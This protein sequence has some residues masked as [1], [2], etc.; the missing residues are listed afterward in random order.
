MRILL[1]LLILQWLL[2][3]FVMLLF[4]M[5]VVVRIIRHYW[6]FPIPGPLTRVID[7][8]IRRRFIQKPGLLAERMH[9]EPG[10]SVVE[11]GP[12]KGSYTLTI[13]ERVAPEGRVFAVDIQEEV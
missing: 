6:H 8:P 11:I 3:I 12:G 9:L 5:C 10:M 2:I 13:A 7:N 4:I 1:W